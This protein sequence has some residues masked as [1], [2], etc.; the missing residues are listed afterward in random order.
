[1]EKREIVTTILSHELAKVKEC[2]NENVKKLNDFQSKIN[3]ETLRITELFNAS[4]RKFKIVMS[5]VESFLQSD[6]QSNT[7]VLSWLEIRNSAKNVSTCKYFDL[8]IT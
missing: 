5:Q 3:S 2:I 8:Q 1:M 7:R 4:M 6:N